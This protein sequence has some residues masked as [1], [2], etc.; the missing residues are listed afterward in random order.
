MKT[1]N[2]FIFVKPYAG[3]KKI[4]TVVKSGFERVD[5]KSKLIKMEVIANAYVKNNNEILEIQKGSFILIKEEIVSTQKS[6]QKRYNIKGEDEFSM[7]PF[8][9]ICG[10][11]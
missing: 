8:S 1:Y 3:V 11:C 7:I 5:Q 10:V 6:I 2:D 4:R 9:I